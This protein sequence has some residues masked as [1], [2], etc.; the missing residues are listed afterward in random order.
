VIDAIYS[1]A[2]VLDAPVQTAGSIQAHGQTYGREGLKR[3]VTLFRTAFP[4]IHFTIE[5]LLVD[6]DQVA[7]QYTFEGTQTGQFGEL[8][9]TGQKISVGG[10]LIA[11]VEA[12]QI[13]SAV[14]VFDSGDMMRQ[15]TPLHSSVLDHLMSEVAGLFRHRA[16]R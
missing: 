15:L 2:Y 7:V 11:A 1:D 13:Q 12:G 4:D 10:M 9:P 5:R 14:S 6:H 3:R 16:P 8:A